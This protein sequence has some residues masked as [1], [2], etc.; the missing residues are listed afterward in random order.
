MFTLTLNLYIYFDQALCLK[1]Q[2]VL[3]IYKLELSLFVCVLLTFFSLYFEWPNVD[4]ISIQSQKFKFQKFYLL[5]IKTIKPKFPR[6]FQ[7]DMHNHKLIKSFRL[8]R[9]LNHIYI[10]QRSIRI[11]THTKWINCQLHTVELKHMQTC[12][13][14]LQMACRRTFTVGSGYGYNPSCNIH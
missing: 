1:S 5:Y 9:K 3:C 7:T 4:R 14:K 13:D 6:A 12:R 2:Y 8:G 10:F 11:Y